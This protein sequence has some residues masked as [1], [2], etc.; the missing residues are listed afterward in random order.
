MSRIPKSLF[1]HRDKNVLGDETS[2]AN[3]LA[4][5]GN[6][7]TDVSLL[8]GAIDLEAQAAQ[9]TTLAFPDAN[10]ANLLINDTSDHVINSTEA[11]NVSFYRRQETSPHRTLA[12]LTRG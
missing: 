12:R 1:D 11:V 9:A 7:L 5:S 6:I 2:D 8:N 10:K 3:R 4:L